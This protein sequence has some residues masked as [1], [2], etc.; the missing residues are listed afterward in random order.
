VIV[1][2]PG[3]GTTRLAWVLVVLVAIGVAR[4][5]AMAALA[6]PRP[7][8]T[9]PVVLA[10]QWT[11]GRLP[12]GCID[13]LVSDTYTAYWLHLAVFGNPRTSGRAMDDDT[14]EPKKGIVRW[15]LPDS[16]SYA[17]TDNLEALP[18]DVRGNVDVLVR[19]GPAAVVKRRGPSRCAEK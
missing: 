11:R 18:R 1:R 4:P 10:A 2:A 6:R 16:L 14:F 13:Y 17:I 5:T 8:V 12:P 19:F 15:I 9:Q 3:S 7:V